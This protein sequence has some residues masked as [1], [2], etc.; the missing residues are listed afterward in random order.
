MMTASW[1]FTQTRFD[2][3][4]TPGF[5]S[6]DIRPSHYRLH[7][8][9]DPKSNRFSGRATISIKVEQESSNITLHADDLAAT[10]ASIASV[11]RGF[12]ARALRLEENPRTQTWRLTPKDGKAIAAGQYLVTIAYTGNV[13]NHASGLYRA[14][15]K[16]NGQSS[17]MLATQLEAVFARKLF[18]AFDEPVFRSVFEV[19]I[20]APSHYDVYANMPA[21][22]VR[23]QGEK[24]LHTFKLT[25]LMPTYLVAFTVGEFDALKGQSGR[26]PLRIL[27]APGRQAQASYAMEVT[28][29][30]L[31]FYKSYFGIDYALP[32]LDQLAVPSTR[33][34]AMEDWGLISYAETALLFDPSKSGAHRQRQIFSTVAHEV[35][36]QWFGNLVTAASWEEIWLNEAFATWMAEKATDH[37]NP[38][39]TVSLRRRQPIDWAMIKDASSAT[40]A[41]RSGSVQEDR[42]FDVFD[43]IT[44]SK[45]SAVLGMIESW[46]GP[47]VFQIG[48]AA[49][50]KNQQ[51]SNAT[52]ADLWFHIGQAAGRDVSNV[53]R[54]WTDQK[55]FPLLQVSARC[56]KGH[57]QIKIQQQR[58]S[59]DTEAI[60][61]SIWK[62]PLIVSQGDK[63]HRLLLT[64]ARQDFVMPGCSKLPLMVNAGGQGFYRVQYTP[65]M[66]TRLVKEFASLPPIARITLLSDSFA[67]LQTGQLSMSGYWSLL[68][69]LPTV[70]GIG[71]S[72]LLDIARENLEFLYAVYA[73]TPAESLFSAK[74]RQLL[75]PELKALGWSAQ[76]G[77][78][79]EIQLLRN[80][81]I[82]SLA[83]LG[84]ETVLEQ[85]DQLFRLDQAGT[86][87]L[88]PEIRDAVLY[89]V[90]KRAD[91]DRHASLLQRLLS[92]NSEE[93][94]WR[95][96]KAIAAVEDTVL[97]R[98][99]LGLALLGLLPSNI[100]SRLPAMVSD[101]SLHS[102]M[103]YQFVLEHFTE[104]TKLSGEMFGAS[105][106]LLPAAA[107][108]FNTEDRAKQLVAD[109]Q[110][111]IG[112]KGAKAAAQIAAQI[113]L[114]AAIRQREPFP[115]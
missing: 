60:G 44:Y 94:R 18:P 35:A 108:S 19:S 80:G 25:P 52:A 4:A 55:G 62:V 112:E 97:A 92:A 37:F 7:F 27:T 105:S 29:K 56:E 57:T 84:D 88:R 45:G 28:Q 111:R 48:L 69:Q 110:Q 1:A 72:T 40:R 39:W 66:Y 83:H 113:K 115:H 91:A 12:E 76:A 71:R 99:V 41:I 22:S 63:T 98:Q 54:S 3:N 31:P 58:F 104:F 64:K 43:E 50:M 87:P 67:L 10:E 106:W 74:A 51:F 65:E 107:S 33:D 47:D 16:V 53:A 11:R 30:V 26:V 46:L 100:A 59:T 114:K 78:S 5:L 101:N 2:F 81:L 68:A 14:P 79:S 17:D 38:E 82:G 109:Q 77:E 6:K 34:G 95:Y 8:D 102:A 90:G 32:K 75:A 85:A 49:Y 9:V 42:V 24:K 93:D 61:Q 20:E 15:Y 103:A 73:G 36:H 23:V 70:R 13:N 86:Q 96:A 89:A 21:Q